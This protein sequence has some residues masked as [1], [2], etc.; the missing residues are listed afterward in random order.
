M[1]PEGAVKIVFRKEIEAAESPEQ[2]QAELTQ[3]YRTELASPFVAA[4]RG[5]LDDIL[6]PE[7]CRARLIAA[8]EALTGKRQAVPARKHGNIPL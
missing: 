5:Y 8:F 1:G 3:R 4:T 2:T 7:E 6:E